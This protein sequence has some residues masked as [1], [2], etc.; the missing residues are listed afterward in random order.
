MSTN[1][2]ILNYEFALNQLG[3]NKA[4]LSKMLNKFFSEFENIS[5]EIADFIEA[6]DIKSA[7]TLVHTVKG[8]SGNIGLQALYNCA[9]RFD[10]ELRTG[11][12]NQAIIDEFSTVVNVTCLEIQ[13]TEQNEAAKIQQTNSFLSLDKCK[14]ELIERLKRNEFIDDETLL[15]YVAGLGFP[16][17]DAKHLIQLIEDLRYP[18][19]I[20]KIEENT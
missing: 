1:F 11:M 6:N 2:P 10:E 14:S 19:A 7:K 18:Q 16:E 3:G 17:S 5:A 15:N 8:I 4:L 9:T 13:Q 12:P 20:V